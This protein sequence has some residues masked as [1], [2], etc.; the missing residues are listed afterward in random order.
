MAKKTSVLSVQEKQIK[1]K[2]KRIVKKRRSMKIDYSDI[3]PS[4]DKE[5]KRARPVGRPTKDVVKQLI[6]IRIDP[7]LLAKL[8]KMVNKQNDYYQSLIHR[9]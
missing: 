1:K 7:R 2:D 8:K 4:T 6:A 9:I 3:P 5:L